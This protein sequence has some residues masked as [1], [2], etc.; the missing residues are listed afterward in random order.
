[1]P[2]W[3]AQNQLVTPQDAFRFV[4]GRHAQFTQSATANNPALLD[5]IPT[6]YLWINRRVAKARGIKF[7]DMVEV[8]SKV[9]ATVLPAYPTEKIG[10]QTLFFVHGF[11]V[12]S[13]NMRLAHNNGGHGSAILEDSVEPVHG[14]TCLHDTI[15][16]IKKV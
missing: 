16:S 11:G 14:S 3:H 6:N 1:M 15:V 4:T 7:G 13:Q 9:G 10:P 5:L 2:T 12:Q 8:K